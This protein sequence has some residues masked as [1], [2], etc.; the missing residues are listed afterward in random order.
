MHVTPRVPWGG[1]VHI[2]GKLYGGYL[3]A[4]GA[5]VRLRYGYGRRARTTFGVV[6]VKGHGRFATSFHFGPGPARLHVHYWF[7]A[8]LLAHPDYPW[9]P[10]SS[11]RRYVLVGGHPRV[12][13]PLRLDSNM[14]GSLEP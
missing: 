13:L 2:A 8:S 12:L 11:R 14:T 9:A 1:T 7:S 5:A 3:P 10:A 4:G 6:H